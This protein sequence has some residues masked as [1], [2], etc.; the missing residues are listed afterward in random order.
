MRNFPLAAYARTL[1]QYW[2]NPKGRQDLADF[3]VAACFVT[4]ATV[5]I[6]ALFELVL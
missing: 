6:I 4:M 3:F 5:A 2:Q 1:R